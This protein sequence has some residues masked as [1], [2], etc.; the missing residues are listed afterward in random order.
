MSLLPA[1]LK[2]KLRAAARLIAYEDGQLIHNRGDQ[3]PGL[4]IV[5]SGAA[6]I[7]VFGEDGSF[8]TVAILGEGQSFGE[9]T[10]FADLPR[11]HDATAIGSS[12][13][14]QIQGPAFMRLFDAEPAIARALLVVALR[15]SHAL[16][17]NI[18]DMRRLSLPA[19][20]AKYLLSMAAEDAPR[21]QVACKQ[22]ELA[23]A[24]GVSRVSLGKALKKLETLGLIS[25]GYGRIDIPSRGALAAWIEREAGPALLPI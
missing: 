1:S 19:R 13:V 25:L 7:G 23:F 4:S 16:A 8:L 3:K 20:T 5:K 14:Y 10:L 11:T 15:R 24:L 22:S 17:Q 12:E 18:D 2:D 6:R 21:A 9:H